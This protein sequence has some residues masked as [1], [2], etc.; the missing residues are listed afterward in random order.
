MFSLCLLL[1]SLSLSSA[2]LQGW[3][4]SLPLPTSAEE[5]AARGRSLHQI[6]KNG[7]FGQFDDG[8]AT[9]TAHFQGLGF[10]RMVR[11]LG[12]CYQISRN[13][14]TGSEFAT[15]F[16]LLPKMWTVEVHVF[17]SEDCD[18]LEHQ[19]ELITMDYD[20]VYLPDHEKNLDRALELPVWA[21]GGYLWTYGMASSCLILRQLSKMFVI[22]VYTQVLHDR[23]RL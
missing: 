17:D 22:Y 18:S 5:A 20:G 13:G 15:K 21:S 7:H 2:R 12:S 19:I 23:E 8:Y 9:F 6:A 16:T 4:D 3:R 14:T 1:A 11:P 10:K